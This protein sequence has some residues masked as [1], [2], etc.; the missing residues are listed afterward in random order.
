MI[1]LNRMQSKV[2]CLQVN[3]ILLQFLQIS[4]NAGIVC[5][6]LLTFDTGLITLSQFILLESPLFFF[7][8]TALALHQLTR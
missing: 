1:S 4:R 3:L 8:A 7:L 6:C 2:K 5:A